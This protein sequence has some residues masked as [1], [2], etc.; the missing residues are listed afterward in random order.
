MVQKQTNQQ[1]KPTPH[2]YVHCQ[3][4]ALC[5]RLSSKHEARPSLPLSN[6]YVIKLLYVFLFFFFKQTHAH[7]RSVDIV[8]ISK[9]L[10]GWRCHTSP[11]W[12]KTWSGPG[13]YLIETKWLWACVYVEETNIQSLNYTH[14]MY[15]V[16]PSNTTMLATANSGFICILACPVRGQT[17]SV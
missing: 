16:I 15:K 4:L 9:H 13:V 1:M 10:I 5:V 2:Y 11:L 12:K 7:I 17:S 14:Q 3:T 6:L 8:C